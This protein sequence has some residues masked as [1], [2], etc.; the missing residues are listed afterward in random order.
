M[1]VAAGIK[2]VESRGNP[3]EIED[4]KKKIINSLIGLTVL[5][6]SYILLTTIN[7]DIINIQNI[8]LGGV[9]ISVPVI[10]PTTPKEEVKNYVFEEIPLG[11]ITEGILMGNSSKKNGLPC[12]EYENDL[13]KIKDK[14]GRIIIG[15]TIDQN[16]DGIIN[17]D[18]YLLNKD[19]FYC[20]KLLDQAIKNKTEYHLKEL[21]NQ[22]D[23]L[24]QNSCS[25]NNCYRDKL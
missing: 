21:I 20:M 24:L 5:L 11:T 25:C 19:I 10:N 16:K 3:S 1:I 18:D 15:D 9:N 7:P 4:A 8:N 23:V 6:T 12:Y 22:L 14:D 13:T 2:L 17:S